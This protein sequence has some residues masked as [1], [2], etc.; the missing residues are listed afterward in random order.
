MDS[1]GVRAWIDFA[2]NNDD[3]F[4]EFPLPL[5]NPTEVDQQRHDL[6]KF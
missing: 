1:P 3:G 6:A 5:G 4:P 2:E